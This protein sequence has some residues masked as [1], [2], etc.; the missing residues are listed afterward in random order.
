M[1]MTKAGLAAV[2]IAAVLIAAGMV[3]AA[4]AAAASGPYTVVTSP[5]S[6]DAVTEDGSRADAVVGAYL[7]VREEDHTG[8]LCQWMPRIRDA[9]TRVFQDHP[10]RVVG[11][12][13]HLEGL[14]GLV[15]GAVNGA[16]RAEVVTAARVF[17]VLHPQGPD[18]EGAENDTVHGC[19]GTT[20]K[21]RKAAS[22]PRKV[23]DVFDDNVR[24]QVKRRTG[25]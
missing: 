6:V 21:A 3:A 25:R 18:S 20:A 19:V 5:F 15:K 23:G 8:L 13:L 17:N 1:A 9:V 10:P 24:S 12:R 11:E 7:D 14:D 4:P 16:L 22:G 2:L